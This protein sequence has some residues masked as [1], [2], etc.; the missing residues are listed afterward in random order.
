M[1]IEEENLSDVVLLK[2]IQELFQS[3][4]KYIDAMSRSKQ[5]NSVETV[6]QL[7]EE[8]ARKK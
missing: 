2:A 4:D 5:F 8:A 1:V 6:V 3:R 7:I